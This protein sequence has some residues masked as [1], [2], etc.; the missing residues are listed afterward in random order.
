MRAKMLEPADV[1]TRIKLLER[2]LERA[3]Q[4]IRAL[5]EARDVA[6]KLVVW[7]GRR[8]EPRPDP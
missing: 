8:V 1:A 6:L 7:G 4:E 2:Q 5:R 3:Q